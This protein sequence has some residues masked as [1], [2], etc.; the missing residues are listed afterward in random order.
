MASTPDRIDAA[1]KS[2]GHSDGIRKQATLRLNSSGSFRLSIY[3]D[4]CV[5]ADIDL[6]DPGKID[7]WWFP[8][9]NVIVLDLGGGDED[10]R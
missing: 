9:K 1:V 2:M 5:A 7:Q 6:D 10:G 8:D 3:K 4:A